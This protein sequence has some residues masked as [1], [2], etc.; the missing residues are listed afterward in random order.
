MRRLLALTVT[1]LAAFVPSAQA[2]PVL[3]STTCGLAGVRDSAGTLRYVVYGAAA[4]VEWYAPAANPPGVYATCLVRVK[5][6]TQVNLHSQ[7]FPSVAATIALPMSGTLSGV[8]ATA[9]V[10]V[11][12][13]VWATG[14]AGSA[15]FSDYDDC[16]EAT[17][18]SGVY[19]R[20]PSA[21]VIN[22]PRF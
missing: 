18:V 1:V 2:A 16:P 13:L 8:E 20:T 17:A 21:R 15:S 14:P 10:E 4:A 22:P 6:G 11:C 3:V 12:T 5:G 9:V 19:V 7:S